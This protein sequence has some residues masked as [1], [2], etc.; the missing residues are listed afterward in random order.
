MLRYDVGVVVVDELEESAGL[1]FR[2]VVHV[3]EVVAVG[4]EPLCFGEVEAIL[5]VT[6]RSRLIEEML[7]NTV[8]VDHR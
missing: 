1:S 8:I 3:E 5:R 4:A 6:L 2:G 7:W